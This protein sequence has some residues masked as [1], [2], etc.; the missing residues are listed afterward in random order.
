[1]LTKKAGLPMLLIGYGHFRGMLM[2]KYLIIIFILIFCLNNVF[3]IKLKNLT[4]IKGVRDNQLIGYGLVVG[5]NG[6]GDGDQTEFTVHTLVN[7]LDRMGITVDENAVRVD[8][9]AAVMVTAT[10][11]PFAKAGSKLDVLVSSIGD[12]DS[13]EGGTLLLTPLSGP[14]GEVYAVAQ[15]PITVG[16]LNVRVPGVKYN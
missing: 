11:T 7:M 4:N 12:A 6:T 5:L 9:V 16:G 3:A 1:M 8:N 14:D 10:M 15:G 13:L 2:K